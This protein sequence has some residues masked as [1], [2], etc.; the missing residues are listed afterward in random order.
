MQIFVFFS[1]QV[2]F[3]HISDNNDANYKYV[4][5]NIIC[6]YFSVR[7]GRYGCSQCSTQRWRKR[8]GT[9]WCGYRWIQKLWRNILS[10]GPHSINRKNVLKILFYNICIVNQTVFF[11]SKKWNIV[12]INETYSDGQ[13]CFVILIPLFCYINYTKQHVTIRLDLLTCRDNFSIIIYS[14]F[15]S[16]YLFNNTIIQSIKFLLNRHKSIFQK[17]AHIFCRPIF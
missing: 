2:I 6:L 7:Y 12:I 8:C 11:H 13:N 1:L 16:M 5:Y 10:R 15:S 9:R 3:L 4:P 14:S 17:Q